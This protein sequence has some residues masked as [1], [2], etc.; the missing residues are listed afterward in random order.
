M[1]TWLGMELPSQF[2]VTGEAAPCKGS[3]VRQRERISRFIPAC[4]CKEDFKFNT[5]LPYLDYV[6]AIC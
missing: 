4:A 6:Y 1:E 2:V 5:Q 3:K